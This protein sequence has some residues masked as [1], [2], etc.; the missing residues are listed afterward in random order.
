MSVTK[1][2][3]RKIICDNKEYIWYVSLDDESPFYLLNVISEDKRTIL[4]CPLNTGTSYVISKGKIF[5]GEKTDGKWNRYLLPFGVPE[6]ITPRFVAE[7]ISWA[8]RGGNVKKLDGG[9]VAV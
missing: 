4:T 1:R 9:D 3:R 6:I 5:Q 8:T 2:N 7:L